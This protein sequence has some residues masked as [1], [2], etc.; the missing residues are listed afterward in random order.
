MTILFTLIILTLHYYS[1]NLYKKS[2]IKHINY[3]NFSV[4]LMSQLP[5]KVCFPKT[6]LIYNYSDCVI[7]NMLYLCGTGTWD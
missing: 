6:E 3:G 5:Q 2:F 4:K 1:S 7:T